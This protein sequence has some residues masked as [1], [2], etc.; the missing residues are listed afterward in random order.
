MLLT[1]HFTFEEFVKSSRVIPAEF[2]IQ[3]FE[4]LKETAT[5]LEGVRKIVGDLP[6]YISTDGGLR[7]YETNKLNGGAKTSQHLEGEAADFSCVKDAMEVFN[8][9][10][11]SFLT[12]G[13]LIAYPDRKFCHIST[14]T[15]REC[16]IATKNQYGEPVYQRVP[17]EAK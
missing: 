9:I 16:L 5:L 10:R 1:K 6:L 3:K 17:L 4:K 13:Q 15:K 14:G 7:T 11:A 12:W 8:L 2:A